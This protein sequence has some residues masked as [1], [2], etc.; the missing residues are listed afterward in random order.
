MLAAKITFQGEETF[1]KEIWPRSLKDP[2]TGGSC[3]IMLRQSASSANEHSV[4][5]QIF[6]A[7]FLARYMRKGFRT[8]T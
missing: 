5:S 7:L 4:S 3:Y 6:S 2:D 1:S 8:E